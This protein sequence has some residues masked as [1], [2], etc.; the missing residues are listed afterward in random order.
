MRK[1]WVVAGVAVALAAGGAVAAAGR[2]GARSASSAPASGR[3]DSD[4]C[5]E[6]GWSIGRGARHCEVREFSLPAGTRLEVDGS[7]NGGVDVE[8][9]TRADVRVQARIDARAATEAEA[10]ALAAQVTLTQSGVLRAS[11]PEARGRRQWSVSWRLRVPTRSDL[12][13]RAENGGLQVAGV[14]G[15]VEARTTNGGVHLADVGGRVAAHTV[16]GGLHVSLSDGWRGASL[17]AR[18]TN[19]GVHLELPR[20]IDARVEA[21]TVNGPIHSDLPV[22]GGRRGPVTIG[23]SISADLGRGGAPLR[24]STTNGGLHVERR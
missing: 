9:E 4:W 5:R 12:V 19:G 17:E 20:Q 21:S 16:N 11:G 23:G 8:G 6:D 15:N 3:A 14:D 22:T 10:R 24:V 7:P 13:L 2:S 18:T 1:T